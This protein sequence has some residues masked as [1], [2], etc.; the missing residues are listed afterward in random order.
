MNAPTNIPRARWQD[1]RTTVLP[2]FPRATDEELEMRSRLL[3]IRDL[4]IQA[5]SYSG[6]EAFYLLRAIAEMANR[7]ALA[8]ITLAQLTEMRRIL[9]MA[10][11]AAN[12]MQVLV[13]DIHHSRAEGSDDSG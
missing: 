1:H 9:V 6:D 13:N 2:I 8:D 3:L 12:S 11:A 5:L 10:S 7:Y 4:A